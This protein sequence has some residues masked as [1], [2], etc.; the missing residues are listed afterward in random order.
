M[1]WEIYAYG[2]GDFLRIIFNGIASIFGDDSY[3]RALKVAGTSGVV[4]VLIAVSFGKQPI[5]NFK[6]FMGMVF[7][8]FVCVVP[9]VDVRIV[10]R[11]VPGNSAVVANVPIG[12][13][14]TASAL[15]EAG[16]Y[17]A[18][19]FETIFSLPTGQNYTDRGMMFHKKVFDAYRNIEAVAP[20]TNRN[21]SSL[22][23]N[24]LYKPAALGYFELEEPF[25]T[26]DLVT[27]GRANFPQNAFG[28]MY[29]NSSGTTSYQACRP[30]FNSI[31]AD[32]ANNEDAIVSAAIS[33]FMTAN[34]TSTAVR[35]QF[36]ND[37]GD[38]LQAM[39]N[40]SKSTGDHVLQA[41]LVSALNQ[42]PL[43]AGA[44][45]D[46]N[47][48]VQAF[49]AKK[50]EAERKTTYQTMG[51][52][53][54]K[55]LPLLRGLFEAFLYCVFPIVVLLALFA[56]SKASLAYVKA[57][58]WINMWAPLYAILNFAMVYFDAEKRSNIVT[59]SGNGFS[60]EAMTQLV[61][62]LS[63]TAATAGYLSISIPVMAWMLVSNA[64]SLMSSL[65][66]RVVSGYEGTVSSAASETATGGINTGQMSINSHSGDQRNYQPNTTVGEQMTKQ[67]AGNGDAI[68]TSA[69]GN[70]SIQSMK[71]DSNV[72]LDV[73]SAITESE[74]TQVT[75]AQ[76]SLDEK[77]ASLTQANSSAKTEL[78]QVANR[79]E[80]SGQVQEA[81]QLRDMI[82]STNTFGT[83]KG[84]SSKAST[85]ETATSSDT[86]A[87][88]AGVSGSLGFNSPLGGV[89]ATASATAT[90]SEVEA[91]T[92]SRGSTAEAAIK[93]SQQL[94]DASEYAQ[95]A[96]ASSGLTDAQTVSD[97]LSV[98]NNELTSAST[99][100]SQ[101][102]RS[103]QSAENSLSQE[104]SR[105]ETVSLNGNQVALNQAKREAV[106]NGLSADAG[107]AQYRALENTAMRGDSAAERQ[108]AIGELNSMMQ[109]GLEHN[110]VQL[111][112]NINSGVDAAASS[113]SAG[114]ALQ[115]EVGI[116]ALKDENSGFTNSVR[117]GIESGN[118]N[119][120]GQGA[121]VQGIVDSGSGHVSG[122][123]DQRNEATNEGVGVGLREADK[124]YPEKVFEDTL[125]VDKNYDGKYDSA[126]KYQ[127]DV[128]LDKL[129]QERG[130]TDVT[131]RPD[132]INRLE[133]DAP[134]TTSYYNVSN[135]SIVKG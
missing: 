13:G 62:M 22:Y 120:S 14:F 99:Q 47:A 12:L 27:W 117:S 118:D 59:N 25:K 33:D 87:A 72:N 90:T 91:E 74:R 122:V 80:K 58:V 18:R 34:V 28:I 65:G 124:S 17:F 88:S 36:K 83:E 52:I 81:N 1:T 19:T 49:T 95:T 112:T 48:F 116:Q 66:N 135:S 98:T 53:A 78:S 105:A 5:D 115:G 125:N 61:P 82:G 57:L 73:K 9:K 101:S 38:A 92:L 97:G 31:I 86:E 94:K 41:S 23:T 15:S 30:A 2:F 8:Y 111:D 24:C 4:G 103:L 79:L 3:T 56:P 45:F 84:Q 123:I 85:M 131:T 114:V 110:G 46:S 64:G 77:T 106:E 89:K 39:G 6:W 130:D 11:V 50:A 67:V 40:I 55:N 104:E 37:M 54:T 16:D 32:L 133:R 70:T 102:Y 10:D 75:N 121:V 26:G 51:R 109:R 63:D 68:T 100:A 119:V 35:T 44:K 76:Q 20:R 107:V 113:N 69:D 42:S 21:L 108:Q 29:E 126:A 93:E 128:K 96:L 127:D 7:F 132:Y 60:S 134:E 71:T 43:Q 129:E